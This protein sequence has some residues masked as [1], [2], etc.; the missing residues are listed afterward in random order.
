MDRSGNFLPPY[1]STRRTVWLLSTLLLLGA[2]ASS[3]SAGFEISEIQL[4]SRQIGGEDVSA[5]ERWSHSATRTL[6]GSVRVVLLIG[7]LVGFIVWLHRARVNARAFGAP[8]L[9]EAPG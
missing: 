2:A 7:T 8:S 5:H 1:V 4:L 3:L 6:L 9:E